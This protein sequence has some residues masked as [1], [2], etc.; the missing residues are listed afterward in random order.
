MDGFFIRA[1]Y[2]GLSWWVKLFDI[3]QGFSNLSDNLNK[4]YVTNDNKLKELEK[5]SHLINISTR[6]LFV[7]CRPPQSFLDKRASHR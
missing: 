7:K 1:P 2:N 5:C 3:S 6:E 4:S